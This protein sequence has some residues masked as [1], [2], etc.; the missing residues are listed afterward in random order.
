MHGI[1]LHLL[2][3]NCEIAS[4]STIFLTGSCW[5][6]TRQPIISISCLKVTPSWL[7]WIIHRGPSPCS[8]WLS[9][10]LFA[11]SVTRQP[12]LSSQWTFSQWPRSP[13]LLLIVCL[14]CLC[15]L[16]TS[17]WISLLWLLTSPVTRILTLRSMHTDLHLEDAVMQGQS[18]C[19]MD[20]RDYVSLSR[21]WAVGR[22]YILV[23]SCSYF[24]F[25]A[26]E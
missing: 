22:V 23:F 4:A 6:C 12:S 17:G 15:F 24:S 16:C 25:G 8:Q 11:S 13:T 10:V 21:L 18:Y 14:V 20:T 19:V 3:A 7:M 26:G 5:P 1:N 9:C 2:A